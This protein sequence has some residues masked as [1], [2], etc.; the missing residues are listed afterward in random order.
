MAMPSFMRFGFSRR[1]AALHVKRPSSLSEKRARFD[2]EVQK[3]VDAAA[4][5]RVKDADEVFD[6]L[7]A[8]YEA[9][10]KRAK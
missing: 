10:S 7:E 2:A 8:K 6:R 3:G 9:M 4:E 1:N 5:G